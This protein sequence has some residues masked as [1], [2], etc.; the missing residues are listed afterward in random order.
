M[1]KIA[2]RIWFALAAVS[3]VVATAAL[4]QAKI[5]AGS[6]PASVETNRGILSVLSIRSIRP[7]RLPRTRDN[8]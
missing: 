2:P 8:A 6:H 1:S 5:T 7:P 3:V 4:T